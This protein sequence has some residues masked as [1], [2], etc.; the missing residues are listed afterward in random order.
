MKHANNQAWSGLLTRLELADDGST[1][2]SLL[3]AYTGKD[4][5]YHS[6]AHIDDCLE[7]LANCGLPPEQADPIALALWFHDAVYDWRS[8]TNEADSAAL[9]F[10]FMETAQAKPVFGQTGASAPLQ[11]RV[12][13]LIMATRHDAAAINEDSALIIDIDLSILGRE[14]TT[15]DRYERAIRAEYRWVPALIYARE[16]RKVLQGFLDR[17]A[18]FQTR[19]FIG[20]ECQARLNL[21]KAIDALR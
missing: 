11:Q 5:H 3:T 10:K 2:A 15:Y 1:Y 9:A 12:S 19:H 20:C 7:Q 6:L 18:I 21:S 17:P 16:R 14:P 4:R 8:K 13:D